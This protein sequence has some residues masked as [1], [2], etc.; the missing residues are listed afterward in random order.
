MTTYWKAVEQ[1]ITVVLF[2]LAIL[3]AVGIIGKFISFGFGTIGR[4]SVANF[5]NSFYQVKY[6][7]AQVDT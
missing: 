1:Y 6:A 3:P 5:N 7:F 4:D 2:V